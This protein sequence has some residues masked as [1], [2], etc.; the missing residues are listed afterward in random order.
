VELGID[1][2]DPLQITNPIRELKDKYQERVT[3]VG[4]FDNQN[5]FDRVGVTE[6]ENRGEVVRAYS[7]MAPGGSSVA[8]PLTVTF[9]FVPI[10]ID[11]HFKHAF[12]FGEQ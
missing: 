4:G 2:I 11:E 12:R 6:E 10:F 5:V 1:A 3:F 8:F 9:D 7:E